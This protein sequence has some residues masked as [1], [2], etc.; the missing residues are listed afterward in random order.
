MRL[1]Q[2]QDT[3]SIWINGDQKFNVDVFMSTVS[4]LGIKRNHRILTSCG[5][6][7]SLDEIQTDSGF[8]YV[9]QEFDEFAGVTIYSDS[10]ALMNIIFDAMLGSGYYHERA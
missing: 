5:P 3:F 7:Q 10:A 6:A 1:M 9:S 4:Q 8:F 2:Q